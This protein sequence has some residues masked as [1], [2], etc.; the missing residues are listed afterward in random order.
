MAGTEAVG[1]VAELGGGAGM[2]RGVSP[3][4][5]GLEPSGV[6]LAAVQGVVGRAVHTVTV[7]LP[8]TPGSDVQQWTDLGLFIANSCYNWSCLV[9]A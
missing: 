6:V 2:L 8:R 3:G 4:S 1:G 5:W 7:H 9:E